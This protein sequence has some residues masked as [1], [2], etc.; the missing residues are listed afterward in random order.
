MLSIEEKQRRTE[1]W[2]GGF[3]A[4]LEQE[5]ADLGRRK[6]EL[7]NMARSDHIHFLKVSP[8]GRAVAAG[9]AWLTR[10]CSTSP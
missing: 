5:V 9:S 7:E 3:L 8:V 1:R 4:E 10:L 2:A 6:R